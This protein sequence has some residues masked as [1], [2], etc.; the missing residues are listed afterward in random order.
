MI[1]ENIDKLSFTNIK[2]LNSLKA[3]KKI[4]RLIIENICNTCI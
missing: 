1:K 3:I 2:N 4:K